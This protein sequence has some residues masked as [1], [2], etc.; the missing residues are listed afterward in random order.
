MEKKSAQEPRSRNWSK[1]QG[2]GLLAGLLACFLWPQGGTTQI[3][4]GPPTPTQMHK[5]SRLIY[6]NQLCSE[7]EKEGSLLEISI[8]TSLMGIN[9]T[10]T[11]KGFMFYQH[12]AL[13][14][15]VRR[16]LGGQWSP[17]SLAE[18]EAVLRNWPHLYT[19]LGEHGCCCLAFA[20]LSQGN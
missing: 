12:F 14:L 19:H 4:L 17:T 9:D 18:A 11:G 3:G 6:L 13:L 20:S 2:V 15:S 7:Q 8:Q 5:F 10:M 16:K 1:D